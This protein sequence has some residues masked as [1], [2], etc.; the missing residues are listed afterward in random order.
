MTMKAFF[1]LLAAGAIFTAG[2]QQPAGTGNQTADTVTTTHTVP[3][4]APLQ[5][6]QCFT[7]VVGR[8]T[9]HLR[10][11]I[12]ND[13]V[14]GQL[15]YRRY[16]KDS[17]K[18]EIKG[19]FHDKLLDVQYHFMSEGTMSTHPAIFRME[20]DKVFEGRPSSFDKEGKP[21]FARDPGY[22]PFDS[23]PFVKGVCE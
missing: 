21:V 11:E 16:E 3:D 14:S 17:N 19:T 6:P 10:F 20:G 13:S 9:A 22:I 1:L 5:G 23:I 2:C 12:V 7:Q 8:D 4:A 15:E 18:G